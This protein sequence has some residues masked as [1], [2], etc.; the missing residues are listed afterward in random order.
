MP[1]D[2]WPPLLHIA[3]GPYA[4]MEKEHSPRQLNSSDT[5]ATFWSCSVQKSIFHF[6][7]CWTYATPTPLHLASLHSPFSLHA[8][9]QKMTHTTLSGTPPLCITV[10]SVSRNR[11]VPNGHCHPPP[12]SPRYYRAICDIL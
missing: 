4:H 9:Y 10:T 6:Q 7:H 8:T 2:R 5:A 3:S 1:L 11:R 12:P